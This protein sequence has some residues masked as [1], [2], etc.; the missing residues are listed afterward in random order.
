MAK[1]ERFTREK[2]DRKVEEA[3]RLTTLPKGDWEGV[4]E[5]IRAVAEVIATSPSR[6]LNPV[7]PFK[8]L[9]PPPVRRL[10]KIE[11]AASALGTA[12]KAADSETRIALIGAD[13]IPPR[14]AEDWPNRNLVTRLERDLSDLASAISTLRAAAGRPRAWTGNAVAHELALA[15][16]AEGL[17]FG[18]NDSAP[19]VEFVDY[20]FKTAGTLYCP[21]KREEDEAG[22][23]TGLPW[24]R[25]YARI[26]ADLA[27]RAEAAEAAAAVRAFAE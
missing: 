21:P 17:P 27:T 24:S 23:A 12:I 2:L 11:R 14:E 6:N 3:L 9:K 8:A 26:W 22:W 16:R 13:P 4:K 15:W 20:V 5:R 19:W 7:K 10:A 25:K 18:A 1:R